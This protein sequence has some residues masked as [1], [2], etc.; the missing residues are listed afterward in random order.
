MSTACVAMRTQLNRCVVASKL[1]LEAWPAGHCRQAYPAICDAR[2]A[3][4]VRA[5]DLLPISFALSEWKRRAREEISQVDVGS[6]P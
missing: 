4:C 1:L 6:Y 5:L 3:V 2:S